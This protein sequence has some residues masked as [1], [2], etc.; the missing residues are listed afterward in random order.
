MRTANWSFV[1]SVALSLVVLGCGG[2]STPKGSISPQAVTGVATADSPVT[3]VSLKGS[4]EATNVL[5]TTPDASGRFAFNVAG[6][7]AP[8]R[9]KADSASGA[10]YGVAAQTGVTNVNSLTTVVV[11]ASSESND[12]ATSWSGRESRSS[13][14]IER[15]LKSLQ[16]VL[17]PLFD[18][19]GITRIDDDD[20]AVIALLQDVSFVVKGRA[21][22]V[23]NKA[24]GAIIFTAPLNALA[25]GTFVP[26]NMPLGPSGSPPSACT[27][28]YSAWGAC[29]SDGTQTRT[30]SSATPAGCTG[31]P[32]LSQTC[33]Y[34]PPPPATCQYTY[35]AWS[36]CQTDNTQT[37]AVVTSGP[38]GCTGTPVLTQA[39]T[40]VPPPVTCTSFTYSAY[41]AC[42]PNN[43][44]T[45]TVLTS[46]PTGCTGGSPVL[47][48]A[49]TYVPP[50]VTCTSF[51]YSAYGACQSNNT[52]TRTVLTSS[53]TG[54]TGGSPVLT[55]ACTYVPPP[56]TCTSF[57]YSAY[58]ACQPNNT[59][60][61]TVVTSSPAG[62]TGGSP[63]TTQACT[64]VAPC[65]LAT[66]VPS[67]SACHSLPPSSHTGRPNTCASCHGPVDNGTGTPSVGMTATL[68]G[69]TCT[70]NYPTSSATHNKGTINF[71][72][73]Q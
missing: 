35:T 54:C 61:R 4:A 73:A 46:S 5:T 41:G 28:S 17:K 44:Q 33:T 47:T 1:A 26:E 8:F 14:D 59:Q 34:T 48:Q 38:A 53:P 64:Y 71:G 55:Q 2:S 70:L 42:Q 11:A 51:T 21:V 50:P 65:T 18:L 15:V 29:Q 72:A 19:Y 43:T 30:V 22:T 68:S 49:C 10:V 31:T 40:Y 9:L 56:V 36:A 12:P 69:T 60:T 63:V 6:L 37:R 24:T 16:T 66:A 67:C 57:T 39:C 62:C 23:T 45:R 32:I 20:D 25:T 13:Y 7:T 58:G 52:Q 3:S 27:Y